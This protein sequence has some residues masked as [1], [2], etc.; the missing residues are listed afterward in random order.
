[1]RE[2]QIM[3]GKRE[4]HQLDK[5][6]QKLNFDITEHGTKRKMDFEEE[7]YREVDERFVMNIPKW[8]LFE[9]FSIG[10]SS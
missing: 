4:N 8:T 6:I 3:D 1:M 5:K 2:G 7:H 10:W 9:F